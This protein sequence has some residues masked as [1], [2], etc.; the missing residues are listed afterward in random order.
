VVHFDRALLRYDDLFSQELD[1]CLTVFETEAI[2]IAPQ[3]GAEVRNILCDMIPL[4][5]GV[6]LLF[7]LGAFLCEALEALRELLTTRRQILH[8]NDFVLIGVNE[9]LQL[10]L[11]VGSLRVETIHVL[12]EVAPLSL[13]DLRPQGVFVQHG[14][15]GLEELA[16]KGPHEGIEPVSPHEPGR[17]AF[18]T[19][20][21]HRVLP[22][23]LIIAIRVA[24]TNTLLTESLHM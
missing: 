12:L 1:H 5:G 17:A 24:L 21:R 7:D 16:D 4:D 19:A 20:C 10:S 3:E 8:G 9:P 11:D 23:T 6:S 22:R 13:L 15:R 2:D 18:C 14:L